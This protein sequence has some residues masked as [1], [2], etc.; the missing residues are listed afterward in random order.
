MKKKIII[1][2]VG[3]FNAGALG[4]I[5]GKVIGEKIGGTVGAFGGPVGAIVG[6]VVAGIVID[7][8]YDYVVRTLYGSGAKIFSNLSD[9]YTFSN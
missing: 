6:S 3:T 9:K 8:T 2:M 5:V 7:S 4:E 1:G